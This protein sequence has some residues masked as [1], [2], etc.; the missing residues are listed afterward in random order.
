MSRQYR[1]I[2]KRVFLGRSDLEPT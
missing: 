1:I 2:D